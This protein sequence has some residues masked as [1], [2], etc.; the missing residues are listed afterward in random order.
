M[1]KFDWR[2]SQTFAH[3]LLI[4]DLDEASSPRH[5]ALHAAQGGQAGL[6]EEADLLKDSSEPLSRSLGAA[7]RN[8]GSFSHPVRGSEGTLSCRQQEPV[9][10]PLS[11]QGT[12]DGRLPPLSPH[13]ASCP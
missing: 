12:Q 11:C 8:P 4:L 3:T 5:R 10:P 2:M 13:P 1:F 6:A 9:P 7:V